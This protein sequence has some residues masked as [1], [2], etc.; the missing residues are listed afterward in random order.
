MS[1]SLPEGL[2]SDGG[3]AVFVD[4]ANRL[5]FPPVDGGLW[6][7]KDGQHGQ[8]HKAG[9][10]Q[11]VVY[12]IAGGDGE[13]WLG[14]KHGGLTHLRLEGSAFTAETYT[15][16]DG[17]AQNSVYS[18][19]QSRG[20]AVWAGTLSGGVS[21]L[22]H[23]RFT[24]YTNASGLASNTV[25]SILETSDGTMW[26]ATPNGL[27]ALANGRW[28]T[29]RGLDGLPSEDGTVCC[30]IRRVY[31][32]LEPRPAWLSGI[33]GGFACPPE[34]HPRCANK[35]WVLRKIGLDGCGCPPPIT[36]CE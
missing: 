15:E 35:F 36:Y 10:D 14:R 9:L 33:P 17:L 13:L 24:T 27:S 7:V 32:G 21:R 16:K 34:R 3:G 28:Q 12:S 31:F 29:Y 20:A 22:S 4:S 8:V 1:Y 30:R 23:G 18:V 2:P 5:W 26:F 11:D 6:W 25:A 19:Y